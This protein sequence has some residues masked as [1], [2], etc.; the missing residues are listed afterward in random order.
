[1]I[2]IEVGQFYHMKSWPEK[3][4]YLYE[5]GEE[6]NIFHLEKQGELPPAHI[7]P[8]IES[9]LTLTHFYTLITDPDEIGFL[10]L[11]RED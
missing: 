11:Q 1:M 4:F 8:V 6:E 10:H 9:R 5:E 2:E 7:R 3:V